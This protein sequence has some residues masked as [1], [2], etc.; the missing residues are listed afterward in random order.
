M[1]GGGFSL[2]RGKRESVSFAEYP[3]LLGVV[4]AIL[5]KVL[6]LRRE[7]FGAKYLPKEFHEL[8]GNRWGLPGIGVIQKVGVTGFTSFIS[9]FAGNQQS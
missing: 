8:W 3:E 1:W 9:I 2:C 5:Q 7:L 4:L 6:W